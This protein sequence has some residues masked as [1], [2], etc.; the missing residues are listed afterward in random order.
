MGEMHINHLAVFAAAFANMVVG[1]IWYSPKLF[2]ETWKREAAVSDAAIQNMNAA[3]T[4][5]FSFL[6]ALIIAYNLAAFLGDE[7]T[8]V[9]WGATA[10]FLAGVGFAAMIFW[11]IALFEQRS[12]KYIGVNSGYIVIVFTLMGLIIGA[13]R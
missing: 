1:A 9:T 2:Y 11:A 10:G 12:W 7:A 8:T 4:Y 3:K 13:W 5:G 6:A